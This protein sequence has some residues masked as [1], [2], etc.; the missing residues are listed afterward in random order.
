VSALP[1][2][3]HLHM[4]L[5]IFWEWSLRRLWVDMDFAAL[6]GPNGVSCR[7]G[8]PVGWPAIYG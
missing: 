6:A 5:I 7:E 8:W 2:N 4:E 1:L 3:H